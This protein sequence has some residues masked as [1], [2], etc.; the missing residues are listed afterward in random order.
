MNDLLA[1]RYR[2]RKQLGSGG[3]ASIYEAEDTSLGRRVAVKLLHPQFASDP[4]FVQRFEQE[5]RAVAAL[6]HPGIVGVYDVGHDSSQRF[7]VMELVEGR[8]VKDLIREGPLPP[9]R[10]IDIGI[11][12][13]KALDCAH[14]SGIVHRDVKPQNIL[15]APN[16]QAKLIDFGIATSEGVDSLAREGTVLGTV[17]YV[18]PEQAKGETATAASDIYSL[19]VVLYEAATGRMPFEADS[20]VEIATK[21]VSAMPLPPSRVNPRVPLNL[22]RTIL[23]AMAKDPARRPPTAADLAR[24]LLSVDEQEQ[25]TTRVPTPS[26]AAP[27]RSARTPPERLASIRETTAVGPSGS[28]WPLVLLAFLAIALMAGLIP[29][30]SAVLRAG[31]I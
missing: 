16:G 13:S 31:R 17:H 26:M 3:M 9:D 8:S 6:N 18:S 15:V 29:L 1:G 30:W 14:S 4:E 21:H 5:A 11:Q 25:P 20:A 24:E 23:H 10:A 22:E 12:I 28:V 27:T 7:I 19:G 2:L